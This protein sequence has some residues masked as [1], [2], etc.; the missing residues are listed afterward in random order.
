MTYRR[1]QCLSSISDQLL[2]QVLFKKVI[3]RRDIAKGRLDA[4]ALSG[5][6]VCPKVREDILRTQATIGLLHGQVQCP[7]QVPVDVV[8]RMDHKHPVLAVREL[9]GRAAVL[10]GP[11]RRM[12]ALNGSI[13]V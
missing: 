3:Y 5:A 13:T 6:G 10:A 9:A 7:I 1:I 2:C 4:R 8:A 11:P 12:A